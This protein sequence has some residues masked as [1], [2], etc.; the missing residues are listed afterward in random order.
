MSEYSSK[1]QSSDVFWFVIEFEFE[2]KWFV[3]G[4]V[5]AEFEFDDEFIDDGG[6]LKIWEPREE[7]KR[8]AYNDISTESIEI[9]QNG[10]DFTRNEIISRE[11]AVVIVDDDVIVFWKLIGQEWRTNAAKIKERERCDLKVI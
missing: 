10:R 5:E 11:V 3:C 1:V 2:F 8:R 7:D 9:D 6:G 4:G